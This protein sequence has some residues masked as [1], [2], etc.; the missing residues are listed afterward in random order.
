VGRRTKKLGFDVER[1][2][3]GRM[4]AV[5]SASVAFA[6]SCPC[7]DVRAR[8]PQTGGCLDA[9]CDTPLADGPGSGE[10]VCVPTS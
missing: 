7:I 3:G 1:L 2:S 5:I 10:G 9:L 4:M 8:L 6:P